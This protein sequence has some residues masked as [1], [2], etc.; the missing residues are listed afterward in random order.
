MS[1]EWYE[2]FFSP[3]ALQ[4]WRAVIPP[5]ATRDEVDFVERA[6]GPGR[7]G[8]LLDL[9]CGE[10]RHALELARRGHQVTAIDLSPHA[11]TRAGE[12]ARREG[13]SVELRVGDMRSPPPGPFDGACCL[14]NSIG[15]LSHRD[16]RAFLRAMHAALRPGARWVVDTGT[17]AESLLPRF[18]GDDRTLEAAGIRF[19]VR[20]RYDPVE[21]RLR[22]EATLVRGQE[23]QEGPI[24]YGVYT[25]AEL[26]RLFLEAGWS[27]VGLHGALDGRPFAVGDPRLLIVAERRATGA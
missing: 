24:S 8:R 16:L 10:G 13:L 21:G 18:G 15:Y 17:A 2:S 14:G 6:L 26:R 3:L 19:D 7:P 5:G 27:V 20:Q 9:P 25:V 4:F 1:S 11:V 23:R 12:E 22:Q